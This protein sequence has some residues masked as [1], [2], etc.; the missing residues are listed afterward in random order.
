MGQIKPPENGTNQ[1]LPKMGQIK[2]SQMGQ[3][4]MPPNGINHKPLK[5]QTPSQNRTIQTPYNGRNQNPPNGTIQFLPPPKMGQIKPLKNGTQ[6][7]TNQTLP[8]P[9]WDNSKP[10]VLI[11]CVVELGIY[12]WVGITKFWPPRALRWNFFTYGPPFN[13][14]INV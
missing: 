14:E 10:P 1:N 13:K 6:N 3:I 12:S 2:T 7:G 8:P 4:K 5:N 9:K 11:S